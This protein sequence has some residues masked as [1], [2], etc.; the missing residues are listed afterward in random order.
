VKEE[1]EEIET[2]SKEKNG[3]YIDRKS[4]KKIDKQ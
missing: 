2:T 3:R 4:G 1:H